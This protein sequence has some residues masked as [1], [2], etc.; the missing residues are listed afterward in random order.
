MGKHVLASLILPQESHSVKLYAK[1]VAALTLPPGK[2][3]HFEWDTELSGFGYRL[4][5]GSGG[6]V[7]R[8]WNVQYRRGGAT[9]RLLL[10]PAIA[11][12]MP[13]TSAAV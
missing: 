12:C 10:G 11:A 6:K 9:R 8:T 4:R 2:A 1:T 7:L 13:S 5:R 3:D